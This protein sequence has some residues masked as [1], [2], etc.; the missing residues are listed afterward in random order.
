MCK[1]D[2]K[3]HNGYKESRN[4]HILH[5]FYPTVEPGFKIVE[6]HSNVIYVPVNVKRVD[7]ITLSVVDQDGDIVNFRGEVIT[8]RIHLKRL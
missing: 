6:T 5:S 4:E 2:S 7:N 1:R 3:V 8:V